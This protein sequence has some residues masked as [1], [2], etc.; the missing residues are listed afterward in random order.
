MDGQG[1][2]VRG[3]HVHIGEVA[4]LTGLSHRTIRYYEE[5]G[6]VTPAART[7]GGFRLYDDADIARLLL[8]RPM[9]PLGFSVEDMRALLEALDVLADPAGEP[10]REAQAREHVAA[11]YADA[12]QR[13][14]DLRRTTARAEELTASLREAMATPPPPPG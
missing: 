2:G 6:L 3:R 10:A 11:V 9:K 4:E 1:E 7:D 14:T 13:L 8:V 12:E 5:M